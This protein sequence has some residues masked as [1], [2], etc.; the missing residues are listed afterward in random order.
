[1]EVVKRYIV[2]VKISIEG[3]NFGT[4]VIAP[5]TLKSE[6]MGRQCNSPKSSTE[7]YHASNSSLFGST[8][9]RTGKMHTKS[10]ILML[11]Q[12]YL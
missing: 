5:L 12:H 11:K 6:D 1:M 10:Y 7:R 2:I 4:S 8:P 9:K 3:D